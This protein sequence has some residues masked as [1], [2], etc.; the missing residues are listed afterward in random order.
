MVSNETMTRMAAF[1][2]WHPVLASKELR[3]KPVA[4]RL[5][6]RDIVLFRASGGAVGAFDDV[7]PHRRSRL[8]TGDVVGGRLRCPYH[9][10]TFDPSG[11]GE[12]PG[13]P[14][15]TACAVSY[16]VREAWRYV[17]VKPRAAAAEFPTFD[18]DGYTRIGELRHRI[19]VPLELVVDNFT[20]IE[21]TATNHTT[22]GHD[23]SGIG[24]VTI[25]AEATDRSTSVYS[26]GPSKRLPLHQ[27]LVFNV[28]N[29]YRFRS[30]AHTYYSPVYS[31]FDHYW[32]TAD[33][34]REGLIRWRIYIFYVPV[35]ERT[36][37]AVSFMYAKSKWPG[38]RYLWPATSV[39][40]RRELN[41][42]LERDLRLLS[43]MADTNPDLAGMKLSRFDKVL[44]LHRERIDTIYRGLPPNPI[45]AQR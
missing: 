4:A 24:A 25:R 38:A 23:I 26:D 33:G 31:R 3:R 39:I 44:G 12:S 41:R 19:P 29:G 32:T 43:N 16:D 40:F 1:D 36:T 22:F 34:A 35:D 7:C 18:L 27:R 5:H 6:G 45:L 20:E 37:D 9:A 28:W 10:W 21:H 15:L 2:H 14:K 17:W 11:A 13:T 30:D 42:E 8:S